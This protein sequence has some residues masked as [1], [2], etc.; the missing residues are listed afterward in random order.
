MSVFNIA[1]VNY[2]FLYKSFNTKKKAFLKKQEGK[3]WTFGFSKR[4]Y[5]S[6]NFFLYDF[7][8]GHLRFHVLMFLQKLKTSTQ[9]PKKKGSVEE[10]FVK[11]IYREWQRDLQGHCPHLCASRLICTCPWRYYPNVWRCA[12]FFSQVTSLAQ[13]WSNVLQVA[14]VGV[15]WVPRNQEEQGLS[16]GNSRGE[17][18]IIAV[19]M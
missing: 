10:G 5:M 19:I 13:N 3:T 12:I 14:T 1:Y 2:W 7:A 6:S 16:G 18:R 9:E 4:K 11:S 17:I 8:Q 15:G